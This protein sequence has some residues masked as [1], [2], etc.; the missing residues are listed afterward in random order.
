MPEILFICTGNYY[1]SRFA[2]AVF[3]HH[4][5]LSH[6]GWRAFS[7]GLAIELAPQDSSI[8]PHTIDALRR[9]TIAL[10]HT[11]TRPQTLVEADLKRATRVV[12][13]KEAEHRPMIAARFPGWE[14]RVEFW[15]VSDLDQLDPREAVDE[16]DARVR[17]LVSELE[18]TAATQPG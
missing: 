4:S 5:L 18:G 12:A 13:L 15:H 17:A 8:S 14:T 9:R 11:A 6:L 3:N 1:R 2:E 7:R 10:A 16:I